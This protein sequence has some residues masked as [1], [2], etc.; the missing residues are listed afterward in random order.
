MDLGL[1]RD[2]DLPI[3]QAPRGLSAEEKRVKLLE[4]FHE[5]KDFYQL[6]E[7]EKLGP[8]LKGIVSQSVKDV[9]QS[10]VDDNLVCSDKIG[11][12]NFF[13]SFPS[14]KGVMLQKK[15]DNLEATLTS[16]QAAIE[17]LKAATQEEESQRTI[18]PEREAAL[19]RRLELQARLAALHS[20]RQKYGA[21]DPV[22][23]NAK[24]RA[25]ELAKEAANRHTDNT[26][27]IISYFRRTRG[28]DPKDFRAH[29]EIPE[30]WE[31]LSAS[32]PH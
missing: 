2:F 9:L 21:S 8:K 20:E 10:L 32:E 5:S 13:W 30:D 17:T 15:S 28:I 12:S 3:C 22:Q 29:L 27:E 6:K 18:T 1:H 26:M 14:A 31:D 19:A 7:L 24:R 23:I 4:I 16:T 11:T 25:I